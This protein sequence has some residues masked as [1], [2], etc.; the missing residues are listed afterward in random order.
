MI[1]IIVTSLDGPLSVRTC[2]GSI[3]EFTPEDHEVIVM[4]VPRVAGDWA[5]SKA[6]NA[7]AADARGDYLVFLTA[8]TIVTPSWLTLLMNCATETGARVVGPVCNL[9]TGVQKLI[10]AEA[11]V[12][13]G[14]LD[15]Y[16]SKIEDCPRESQGCSVEF[17]ARAGEVHA[18]PGECQD[19]SGDS[20]GC[21]VQAFA[22]LHNH[23]DPAKWRQAIGIAS[24][25]MLVSRELFESLGGFDPRFGSG[26]LA[27]DDFCMRAATSTKVFV[28]GDVY[29]H[30]LG[31]R[32]LLQGEPERAKV[33]DLEARHMCAK[34]NL[35][36]PLA[37]EPR[38]DVVDALNVQG[39][40]VLDLKCRSGATLLDCAFNGASRMVGFEDDR[41]MRSIAASACEGRADIRIVSG[42]RRLQPSEN[43]DVIL[44]VWQLERLAKPIASLRRYKALLTEDGV[45]FAVVRNSWSISRLLP[46]LLTAPPPTYPRPAWGTSA[47]PDDV[48]RWFKEA[49]LSVTAV[50]T[51]FA[52]P[53]NEEPF[54]DSFLR[55]AKRHGFLDDPKREQYSDECWFMARLPGA[56]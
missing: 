27:G 2:L 40:S 15:T 38:M 41:N 8:D 53:R 31:P 3:A 21:D 29:V 32:Y 24:A 56:E 13:R 46:L 28:A 18:C 37:A 39:K 51:A 20:E 55:L 47:A 22:R 12:R 48:L 23:A 19:C 35:D 11:P 34:W 45:F 43:F 1:S 52:P 16:T 7:G 36:D 17:H 50:K 44:S 4:D 9:L 5:L 10:P 14:G 49:G 25:P 30:R 6:M 42:E 26:G 33:M 54:L